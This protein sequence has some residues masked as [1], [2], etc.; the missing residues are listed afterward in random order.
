MSSASFVE[1]RYLLLLTPPNLV[2]LCTAVLHLTNQARTTVARLVFGRAPQRT[3]T[4]PTGEGYYAAAGHKDV[5]AAR[6]RECRESDGRYTAR[7]RSHRHQACIVHIPVGPR[8]CF[9]RRRN[10]YWVRRPQSFLQGNFSRCPYSMRW[11]HSR[12]HGVQKQYQ[13]ASD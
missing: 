3:A 2:K 5:Q 6:E 1:S 9:P 13:G 4:R 12:Y 8:I 10:K 7:R 11:H